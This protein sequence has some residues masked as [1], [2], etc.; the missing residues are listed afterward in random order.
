VALIASLYVSVNVV[1]FALTVGKLAP[2]VTNTGAVVSIVEL[3]VTAVAVNDAASFPVVSWIALL[4]VPLALDGA[5]YATV[6]A[7]FAC[8]GVARVSTTVEPLVAIELTLTGEPATVTT[9]LLDIAV[10]AASASSYVRVNWVPVE[11]NLG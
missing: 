7:L 5:V 8:A 9:K 11:L 3:L 10:V 2:V 6:I 1:P 4:L